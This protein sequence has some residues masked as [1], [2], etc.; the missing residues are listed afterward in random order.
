V[1]IDTVNF[2]FYLFKS[3]IMPVDP[4][5]ALLGTVPVVGGIIGGMINN[6]NTDAT[7]AQN[8]AWASAQQDKQNAYNLSMWKMQTDYNSPQQ[9]MA[10]YT[11]AGLNPNLIYGGGSGTGNLAAPIQ[12]S[13]RAEYTAIPHAPVNGSD[14]G[15]SAVAAFNS[16]RLAGAQ[17]DNTQAQIDL[18]HAQTEK[19]LTDALV[20][21]TSLPFSLDQ[22][23]SET[24]LNNSRSANES[25]LAGHQAQALDSSSRL[26]DVSANVALSKN[27]REQAMLAPSMAEAYQRIANGRISALQSVA[28]AAK[29]QAE[30]ANFIKSGTMLDIENSLAAKGIFKNDPLYQRTIGQ[31]LDRNGLP[32]DLSMGSSPLVNGARILFDHSLLNH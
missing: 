19:N 16:A 32:L 30:T 18:A 8:Q 2:L 12:P 20:S 26:N 23:S 25:M 27:E 13:A 1:L 10:R 22:M 7:N 15:S 3:N 21:R 17:V 31:M 29:A 28:D 6:S 11:A 4:I 9:T 14:I 24:Q 5:S